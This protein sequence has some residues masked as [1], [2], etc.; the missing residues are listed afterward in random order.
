MEQTRNYVDIL[1]NSLERKLEVL[2]KLEIL[3]S[4]EEDVFSNSKVSVEEVKN[5]MDRRDE[6]INKLMQLDSGFEKLFQRVREEIN[7]NKEAYKDEII[8]MQQLIKEISSKSVSIQAVEGRHKEDYAK[9]F[10]KKKQDIVGFKKNNKSV[11]NYYKNMYN[12]H[13]EGSS[14]FLDK[15]K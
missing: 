10:E 9:L 14:Y 4:K 13:Q 5:Y 11:T 3:E 1:V 8:K 7:D 12:S 15:K 2:T 6:Y